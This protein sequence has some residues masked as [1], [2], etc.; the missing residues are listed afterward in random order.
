ML[1]TQE[2]IDYT[3]TFPQHFDNTTLETFQTCP[4]KFELMML[5]GLIPK[6]QARSLSFGAA[7]HL[8]LAV[9]YK[10]IG[11]DFDKLIAIFDEKTNIEY[12]KMLEKLRTLNL[13]ISVELPET[14]LQLRTEL[15]IQY[16]LSELPPL[17]DTQLKEHRTH[18]LLEKI[19]RLYFEFYRYESFKIVYVEQNFIFALPNGKLY[20]GII[21]LVIEWFEKILVME[22]KTASNL[23]NFDEQFNPN[24]QITG[25]ICGLHSL[26]DNA[27]SLA[28]LNAIQVS[29]RKEGPNEKDLARFPNIQR[30]EEQLQEFIVN[31]VDTITQMEEALRRGYFSMTTKSCHQYSGCQFRPICKV[32]PGKERDIIINAF[33]VR[34]FWNPLTRDHLGEKDAKLEVETN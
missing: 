15:A 32:S 5:N 25:Y 27:S 29:P 4:R 31:C 7:V 16:A 18:K 21:D 2:S 28:C 19:L 30:S 23:F 3:K 22:H 12:E 24:Q 13:D 6:H 9:W 34:K 10:T 17:H 14:S 1:L 8:G 11:W 26:I 33:Y 20:S